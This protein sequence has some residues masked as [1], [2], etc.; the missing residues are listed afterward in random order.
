MR[1]LDY[2]EE[3][4]KMLKWEQ[5]YYDAQNALAKKSK[6]FNKILKFERQGI[7][8]IGITNNPKSLTR[9]AMIIYNSGMFKTIKEFEKDLLNSK[10]YDKAL[11]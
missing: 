3:S 4:K 2:I 6:V 10:F 8:N 1:F 11:K 7:N 5:S 9:N